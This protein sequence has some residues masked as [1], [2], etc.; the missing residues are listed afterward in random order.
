MLEALSFA[1]W[2]GREGNEIK[3][4]NVKAVSGM[5]K[6]VFEVQIYV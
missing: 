6:T 1:H 5:S 2:P 3:K 4:S